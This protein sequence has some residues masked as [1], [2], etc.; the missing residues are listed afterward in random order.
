MS[1]TGLLSGARKPVEP[2]GLGSDV[3][4]ECNDTRILDNKREEDDDEDDYDAVADCEVDVQEHI[5]RDPADAIV[6]LEAGG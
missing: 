6:D 1:F 5:Q 2:T 3:T 4:S